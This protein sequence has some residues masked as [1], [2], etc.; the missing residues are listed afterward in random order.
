M[1]HYKISYFVINGSNCI[2]IR[3]VLLDFVALPVGFN[4]ANENT[5]APFCAVVPELS[6]DGGAIAAMYVES[7]VQ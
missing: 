7:V 5:T 6:E 1:I 4:L 2:Q 3:H